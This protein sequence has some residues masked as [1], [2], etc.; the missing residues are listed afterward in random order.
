MSELGQKR[1]WPVTRGKVRNRHHFGRDAG[2]SINE[3]MAIIAVL[4]GTGFDDIDPGRSKYRDC[5]DRG[6]SMIG[7]TSYRRRTQAPAPLR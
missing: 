5:R 4:V 1:T 7:S 2:S 3:N 6:G